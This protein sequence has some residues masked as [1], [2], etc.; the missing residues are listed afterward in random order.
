MPTLA[1]PRSTCG[2]RRSSGSAARRADI[3]VDLQNLL[4]TNYGT[5]FEQQYDYTPPNGGTWINP[6]TILGP[7]FVRLNLTFNF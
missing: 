7:R 4:N 1:G 5:V 6:T 2:L 3:G